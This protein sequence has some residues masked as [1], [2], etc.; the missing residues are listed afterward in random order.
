MHF[1]LTYIRTPFH[2]Y[3]LWLNLFTNFNNK[4]HTHIIDCTH[5]QTYTH[6]HFTHSK[7]FII[8]S[9]LCLLL[10]S[11]TSELPQQ[12]TYQNRA[13]LKNPNSGLRSNI[14][15]ANLYTCASFKKYITHSRFLTSRYLVFNPASSK[16]KLIISPGIWFNVSVYIYIYFVKSVKPKSAMIYSWLHNTNHSRSII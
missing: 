9:I 12:K 2:V 4:T 3:T 13:N 10:F 11:G 8:H 15:T 1:N 5:T 6:E 7:I 16:L 14:F